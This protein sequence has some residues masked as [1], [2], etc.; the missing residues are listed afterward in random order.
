MDSTV[1]AE[2]KEAQRRIKIWRKSR[3]LPDLTD[4]TVILV[5]DG[6]AT[7]AT[8]FT[9]ISMCH[10]KKPAKIIVGAPIASENLEVELKKIVDDVVILEKPSDYH[11]VGQGYVDFQNLTDDETTAFVN[12][13]DNRLKRTL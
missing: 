13:W 4:K 12:A 9:A 7:G 11:A 2:W 3:P 8:L 6:I 5:D 10:K 1:E